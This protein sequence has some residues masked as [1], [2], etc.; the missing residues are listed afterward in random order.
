MSAYR[1]PY[2]R[3]A[4]RDRDAEKR[5]AE[6][7]AEEEQKRNTILNETNFPTLSTARPIDTMVG[8]QFAQLAEKWAKDD[9]LDRRVEDVKKAQEVVDR[10]DTHRLLVRRRNTSRYERH[11][12][13]CDDE[14]LGPLHPTTAPTSTL[15]DGGGWTEVRN[16]KIYK[17][18]RELTVEEM[19]ERER[20]GNVDAEQDEFNGELFESN[21]HD[22]YRV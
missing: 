17:P 13:E 3:N 18:K 10:Q 20:H 1:N 11:E 22:H 14:E 9:A 16:K 6:R 8:N 15:D 4:W 5:Q 21:R 2:K 19:D 12:S 7:T